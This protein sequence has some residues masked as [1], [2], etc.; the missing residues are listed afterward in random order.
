MP[1]LGHVTGILQSRFDRVG[2]QPDLPVERTPDYFLFDGHD[3][4]L[5]PANELISSRD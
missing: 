3:V 1:L 4:Q 5:D 2:V